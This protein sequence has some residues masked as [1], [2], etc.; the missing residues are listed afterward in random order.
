MKNPFRP[1]ILNSRL[2]TAVTIIHP[3]DPVGLV[4][5]GIDT[6]IR[7]VI[8]RTPPDIDISMVGV[9]T[10]RRERPVGRWTVC[11]L[12]GRRFRFFPVLFLPDPS[13]RTVIPL[14]VRF[15]TQLLRK[16]PEINGSILDFHRIEVV[17]PFLM[18]R[19]RKNVFYHQDMEV[20]YNRHSDIKWR[21]F[22]W[23]YKLLER[24]VIPRIDHV[25]AVRRSVVERMASEYATEGKFS[26][27]PTWVDTK[28]FKPL[29]AREKEF[30][31]KKWLGSE[32]ESSKVLV[33]VG[34]LDEQK[35][36]LLLLRA[37]QRVVNTVENVM[38]L[39]V[40]DGP[41]K[42]V[43]TAFLTDNDLIDRV[44]FS[45][46]RRREEVREIVGISDVF[47]LTS[48][49]EGMPI[50]LLEA[51]G[52]GVPV[53]STKVGEVGLAVQQGHN[54]YLVDSE[55]AVDI[56][57]A[58]LECLS[59]GDELRGDRCTTSIQQF[60][61]EKVLRAVYDIYRTQSL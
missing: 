35:N 40:G 44:T 10:H 19:R 3:A 58:I 27:I 7:G 16:R 60:T 51:L 59:R 52:C 36:P 57:S 29:S 42:S 5:G 25:F 11:D 23:L 46:L 45:G 21:Y 20:I 2:Q 49:Y 48:A 14:T 4:P 34:R 6:F 18:D 24:L 39:V 61:P 8:S 33:F 38:L 1:S 9:S 43:M 26:F 47:V 12:D 53:V 31:R 13:A 55:N 22:P 28:V 32:F 17:L 56:S 30:S 37:F 54:G 15:L 41:L 50:A